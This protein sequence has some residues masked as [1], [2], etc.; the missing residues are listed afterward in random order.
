MDEM[1][2]EWHKPMKL[3]LTFSPF[4]QILIFITI[5]KYYIFIFVY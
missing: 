4:V 1:E 2:L 5:Y 3:K